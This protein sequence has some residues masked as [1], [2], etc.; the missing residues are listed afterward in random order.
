MTMKMQNLATLNL[1][2]EQLAAIDAALT[3]LEQQLTGLI[4][5]DFAEKSR[6]AKMGDRSESFTRQTLN[7]LDQNP[8]ILPAGLG[9]A[10]ARADLTARD[11]LR[12]RL[13]RLARLYAR[14]QDTDTALGSDALSI[15]L[16]GY[17][18]L[19]LNGRAAGLEALQKELGSHFARARKTREKNARNASAGVAPDS[20]K[21]GQD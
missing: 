9:I 15:A 19:K 11:R 13:L 4:T 5:L 6:A 17:R 20:P 18:L 16:H 8:E 2:D 3:Q 14:G 1:S 21:P 7:V 10:E 12:P